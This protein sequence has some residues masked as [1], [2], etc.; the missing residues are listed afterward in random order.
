M[1][2]SWGQLSNVKD[3]LVA[4]RRRLKKCWVH[5][6][7]KLVS[8]AIWCGVLGRRGADGFLKVKLHPFKISRFIF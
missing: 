7:R 1:M 3:V 6:I 8:L 4:W 2:V 5:G